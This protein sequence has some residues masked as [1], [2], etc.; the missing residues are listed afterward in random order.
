MRTDNMDLFAKQCSEH[1]L[2]ILH[3]QIRE[4]R[5]CADKEQLLLVGYSMFLR[6]IQADDSITWFLTKR[7]FSLFWPVQPF[8]ERT[9]CIL[10]SWRYAYTAFKWQYV[11]SVVD[12][13]YSLGRG[14]GW[15]LLTKKSMQ[16][17]HGKALGLF[18]FYYYYYY[19]YYYYFFFHFMRFL[20][21]YFKNSHGKELFYLYE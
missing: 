4:G 11:S 20:N 2:S 7:P 6:T 9:T 19:Y 10:Y 8:P 17:P 3:M 12:P 5:C 18:L 1:H 16:T 21:V 13:Q 14:T 15:A